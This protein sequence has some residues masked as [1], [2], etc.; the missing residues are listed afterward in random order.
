MPLDRLQHT[1]GGQGAAPARPDRH[2]RRP[3][4]RYHGQ[5][6]PQ[7]ILPGENSHNHQLGLSSWWCC[8]CCWP[9]FPPL[10]WRSSVT[11]VPRGNC[12]M[13]SGE[14]LRGGWLQVAS[15]GSMRCTTKHLTGL[16]LCLFLFWLYSVRY[17][18]NDVYYI[19]NF[20]LLQ[21]SAFFLFS[22]IRK[23]RLLYIRPVGRLVGRSV[24]RLT[25]PLIFFNI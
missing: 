6:N 9:L 8:S 2:L 5:T 16:S 18:G 4:C 21:I 12:A 15:G 14:R 3:P 24:G 17:R 25:S 1:E 19:P 20:F 22:N 7:G 11:R 10:R 23:G 13:K